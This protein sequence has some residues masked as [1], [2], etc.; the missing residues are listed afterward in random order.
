MIKKVSLFAILLFIVS[1]GQ[2]AAGFD[3][4]HGAFDT[5]L[6]KHVVLTDNGHASLVNY[7]ALM[8][9]KAALSDYMSLLSKVEKETFDGWDKDK[10]LA[11][12]INAYNGFTLEL[13]LTRY[14]NLKSIRDISNPWKKKFIQLLGEKRHLDGIEHGMIRKI[15][16]YD[17]PRIHVALVCAAVSCPALRNEAY[18]YD[19][20]DDQLEDSLIHF[21]AHPERNQYN[22]S[23]DTMRISK[24][25]K[26]YKVDFESGYSD[27][28]SIK[29]TLAKYAHIFTDDAKLQE[30]VKTKRFKIKFLDYNWDL[31]DYKE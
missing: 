25:F 11:F 4:T 10:Q 2:S 28:T 5:L 8:S 26:W 21:F 1:T 9:D 12:L 18:T 14:P 15:S 3:H 13:I 29:D 24:I 16:V 23:K 6:K 17:E 7:T 31:N 22:A 30:R 20:L 27:F 19:K